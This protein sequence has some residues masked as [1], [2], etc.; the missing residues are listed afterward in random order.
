[1][2]LHTAEV[3]VYISTLISSW[4]LIALKERWPSTFGH[5]CSSVTFFSFLLFSLQPNKKGQLQKLPTMNGS[6]DPPGSYDFDLIIIGG[7]SG[8]LAAAKARLSAGDIRVQYPLPRQ[9]SASSAFVHPGSCV[10][11]VNFDREYKDTTL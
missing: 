6:K 11:S 10:Y 4:P 5:C 2:F 8:G 7:G 9:L 1:M 3:G